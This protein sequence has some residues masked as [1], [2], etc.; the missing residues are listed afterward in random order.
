M[1]K[2]STRTHMENIRMKLMVYVT[3][4]KAW[5]TLSVPRGVRPEAMA[6]SYFA[7]DQ[8]RVSLRERDTGW[9]HVVEAMTEVRPLLL[10]LKDQARSAVVA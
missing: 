4:D 2:A 1:G 7:T 5:A 3:S 6:W 10:R 9:T 8:E